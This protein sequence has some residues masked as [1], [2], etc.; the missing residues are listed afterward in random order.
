MTAFDLKDRLRIFIGQL[1]YYFHAGMTSNIA[2]VQEL[3][4]ELAKVL[5]A[6]SIV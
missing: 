6:S 3:V 5:I 2:E 1:I 4:E